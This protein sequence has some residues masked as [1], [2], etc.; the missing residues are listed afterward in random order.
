MNEPDDTLGHSEPLDG[1]SLVNK[2]ER[3]VSIG[4]I[5]FVVMLFGVFALT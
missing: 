4:R 2:S 1:T 3:D 5:G